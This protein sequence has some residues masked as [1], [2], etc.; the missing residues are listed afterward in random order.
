M[1]ELGDKELKLYLKMDWIYNV[2][3]ATDPSLVLHRNMT[4]HP[5]IK[6]YKV[7]RYSVYLAK[8][9]TE[10]FSVLFNK[11]I[12]LD[13]VGSTWEECDKEFLKAYMK[14]ATSDIFRKIYDGIQ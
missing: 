14:W 3:E 7:F 2:V 11:N 6:A 1:A 8:S 9:K 4:V 10:V 13:E 12:S 5:I